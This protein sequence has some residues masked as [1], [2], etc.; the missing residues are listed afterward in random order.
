[1]T[2]IA[3]L[4]HFNKHFKKLIITYAQALSQIT[5]FFGCKIV[6]QYM[7]KTLHYIFAVSTAHFTN[8]FMN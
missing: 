8:H 2:K 3:M 5:I 7:H 1:M 6:V 4:L